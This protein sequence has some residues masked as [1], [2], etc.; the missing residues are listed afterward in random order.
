[1]NLEQ[2]LSPLPA[3]SAGASVCGDDL[4]FDTAFD[5][6]HEL[7]RED[8]PTLSQGEWV[9]ELKRADWPGVVALGTT[10]LNERTKDLR[11]AGW[12][13]DA[14]ARVSGYAGL[15]DG[16]ELVDGLCTRWWAE[17]HPR[18]EAGDA[19]ARVGN[20]AWLLGRVE[21]MAKS[22]TFMQSG[23]ERYGLADLAA[24]RLRKPA[25][26][27][28]DETAQDRARRDRDERVMR[29]LRALGVP[30]L[31]ELGAHAKR[32]RAALRSIEALVDRELGQDGPAFGG[33][34]Q[35][36][37]DAVHEFERLLREGG[38]GTAVRSTVAPVVVART[39]DRGMGTTNIAT[40]APVTRAQA[41][42]Q[43]RLVADFFR[44]T[45]P[46]SPVAYLADKAA[47]WGDMPLHTW[48]RSVMREPSALAHLEELLGVEPPRERE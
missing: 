38:G 8:D 15:A 27:H 23:D 17:V 29:S 33:A 36:L 44:R 46:H 6:I 41:L 28:D 1:M 18:A 26:N 7:R 34:R 25:A 10:L 45:E 24:A 4:S 12:V 43:L 9:R 30:K 48:L 13:L 42:A 2:L 40:G 5:A 3:A 22:A 32:A 14:A 47:Q 20:L 21:S 35:A 37:D 11:V 16:L 31:A 19:D 39:E